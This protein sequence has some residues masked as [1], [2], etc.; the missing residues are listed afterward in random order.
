M[1]VLL[2]FLRP[3]KLYYGPSDKVV[4]V[5]S[6]FC[7]E[8]GLRDVGFGVSWNVERYLFLR[9]FCVGMQLPDVEPA[10][11]GSGCLIEF[12]DGFMEYDPESGGWS[13]I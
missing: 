1:P 3:Y 11:G 5:V 6:L 4:G 12:S 8:L 2:L 13:K 9:L 7:K 10:M